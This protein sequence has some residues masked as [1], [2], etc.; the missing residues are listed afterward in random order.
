LRG[1]TAFAL[2]DIHPGL[3]REGWRGALNPVV[4]DDEGDGLYGTGM[5]PFRVKCRIPYLVQC[6][7]GWMALF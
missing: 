5:A 6:K 3:L 2:E 4:L 7:S 1:L